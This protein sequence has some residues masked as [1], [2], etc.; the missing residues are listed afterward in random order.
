MSPREAPIPQPAFC[1]ICTDERTDL[2]QHSIGRNG[3]LVW[4]CADCADLHPRSGRY[5]FDD[6]SKQGGQALRSHGVDGNRR[7]P[8]RKS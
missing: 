4:V 5:A 7:V 8:A 1:A 6:S 3:A 2:A